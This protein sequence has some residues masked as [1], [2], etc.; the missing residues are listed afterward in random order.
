LS[1][2]TECLW[3][4]INNKNNNSHL[5]IIG[6]TSPCRR[7]NKIKQ[8]FNNTKDREERNGNYF[9][10]ILSIGTNRLGLRGGEEG[11]GRG[12]V[13]GGKWGVEE[14]MGVEGEGTC[15]FSFEGKKDGRV[16]IND[17][18]TRSMRESIIV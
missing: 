5:K 1:L 16:V 3:K 15:D 12:V 2:T 7:S 4:A 11:K 14:D 13:L 17:A 6:F 9:A 10:L 18:G 8:K